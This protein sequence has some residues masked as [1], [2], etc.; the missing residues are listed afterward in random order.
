[1][2]KRKIIKR[3]TAMLLI[4]VV[5]IGGIACGNTSDTT[6]TTMQDP[7][8]NNQNQNQ[9]SE[10]I[11][12]I[13]NNESFKNEDP[14]KT[15]PHPYQFLEEEGYDISQIKNGNLKCFTSSFVKDTEP[16]NLYL[17]VR[18]ETKADAPYYTN[19]LLK[20]TLT[21]KE[22]KDYLKLH[23]GFYVEALLANQAIDMLKNPEV[24]NESRITVEAYD[25]LLKAFKK[26]E[27]VSNLLNGDNVSEFILLDI[28]KT[29]WTFNVLLLGEFRIG[30]YMTNSSYIA[31][32]TVSE[33]SEFIR[34]DNNG[35]LYKPT[36][37]IWLKEELNTATAE[38]SK[39]IQTDTTNN[40]YN[41][42][43][44]ELNK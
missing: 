30:N 1:M 20:Y 16:N 39:M 31:E 43:R 28:N 41:S 18:V 9:Y 19:Y 2:N 23:N 14:S 26:D 3:V 38:K 32:A 40:H 7:N 36:N 13:W 10:F 37:S 22:M 17:T 44:N 25:G 34:I 11:N 8:N 5:V 29:D 33:G 15:K 21:D 35:V 4:F 27:F 6:T 12:Y 42:L 24:V